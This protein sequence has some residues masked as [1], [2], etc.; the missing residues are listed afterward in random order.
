MI[1]LVFRLILLTA[2]LAL[3]AQGE[4]PR[5][6]PTE[7]NSSYDEWAPEASQEEKAQNF[8]RL[9]HPQNMGDPDAADIWMA[10][11]LVD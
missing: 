4:L 6:L 7:V 2:P 1:K 5:L 3:N 10:C 9:G 11:R 8:S